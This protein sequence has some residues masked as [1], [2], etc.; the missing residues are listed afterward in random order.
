MID[1]AAEISKLQKEV[2][3]FNQENAT[4]LTYE[5]RY[6]NIPNRLLSSKVTVKSHVKQKRHRG[7]DTN[8]L[9]LH[10]D[11]DMHDNIIYSFFSSLLALKYNYGQS[12]VGGFVWKSNAK[13]F[14]FRIFIYIM[15]YYFYL[16]V[17]T[18]IHVSKNYCF[19]SGGLGKWNQRT[20]GTTSWL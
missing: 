17:K 2:D 14:C 6:L 19:Q 4:F 8:E 11:K 16:I 20:S 10:W 9:M 1:L 7:E 15:I 18:A 13:V 3:S 12:P 5:K